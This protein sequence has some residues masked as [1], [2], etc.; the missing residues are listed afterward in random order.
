MAE[1][2]RKSARKK[3][4]PQR[5]IG[6]YGL[7]MIT[8]SRDRNVGMQPAG[9]LSIADTSNKKSV[10][11]VVTQSTD[12]VVTTAEAGIEN[13]VGDVPV[14]DVVM[15]SSD[16][17]VTAAEA[18]IEKP[19]RDVPVVD[20]V[21]QSTDLVVTAAEAGIEK[22]VGDV[23]VVD[24]VMQSTDP[25]VTAAEAGIEKPVGDVP[26]VDVVMQSTD[27]VVTAAEAGIEKSVRDVPVVDVVMQ[28]AGPVSTHMTP[29]SDMSV[30]GNVDVT[31]H[32]TYHLPANSISTSG[33]DMWSRECVQSMLE[34]GYPVN[35]NDF[36]V[37]CKHYTDDC[38]FVFVFVV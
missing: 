10:R 7:R 22:P 27:P 2:V 31:M 20:V 28:P 11:D 14:V 25:V 6:W 9:A 15:Q 19:V 33:N 38:Y 37:D 26:V 1:G 35:I 8:A 16:P 29:I 36:C 21:M 4:F 24:V 34:P 18:G 32:S 13:L 17:V 3:V 30:E 23:P 12:P 5:Y